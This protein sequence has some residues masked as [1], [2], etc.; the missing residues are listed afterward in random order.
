[1]KAF[2]L[3]PV[4]VRG[5]GDLATGVAW[6]LFRCGF[7]LLVLELANPLVIRRG[8]AFAN[9][10]FDGACDVEGVRAVFT[11]MPRA[12]E[13]RNEVPVVVDPE[14][15][16]L[17]RLR[18]PIVVDARM[19]KT[20]ND[21]RIDDAPLVIALGPGFEAGRDC[22][23]VVE[24]QRGH[25][26]GRLYESG[27]ALADSGVPGTLGG[28]SVHRLLRAPC[29]GTFVTDVELGAQVHAGQLV[30]HVDGQPVAVHIAGTLRGLL[31][32]G[33]PVRSGF[34]IGDVDPR[35]ASDAYLGVISDKA[36]AVG[37]SV[38]EAI[39][40]RWQGRV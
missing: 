40:G 22:H 7:P 2:P 36:R 30:G 21:T 31:R 19:T 11:E 16:A 13:V 33:T 25:Y 17:R 1:M 8:V 9:A 38:L 26:L 14:G 20:R 10:V 37:G 15:D 27:A 3:P 35:P 4:V 5:G 24:T 6:R 18:P 39:L 29:D 12:I 34:K 32:S 28:E 23:F